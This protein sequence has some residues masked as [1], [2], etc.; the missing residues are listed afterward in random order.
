MDVVVNVGG[1]QGE[2]GRA[3]AA[4]QK[5]GQQEK[6]HGAGGRRRRLDA[7][8]CPRAQVVAG[9]KRRWRKAGWKAHRKTQTP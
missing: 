4:Q 5:L 9:R 8:I 6:Q 3:A 2:K 1:A 7:V